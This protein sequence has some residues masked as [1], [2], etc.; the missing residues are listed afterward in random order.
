[1]LMELVSANRVFSRIEHLYVGC[2]LVDKMSKVNKGPLKEHT[3]AELYVNK[4]R[5]LMGHV[6]SK[7]DEWKV[8]WTHEWNDTV[9][10]FVEQNNFWK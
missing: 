6:M 7:P 9:N 4:F 3:W 1:M 5:I 2:S 10:F 8:R